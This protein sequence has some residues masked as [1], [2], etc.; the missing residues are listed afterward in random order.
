MIPTGFWLGPLVRRPWQRGNLVAI[1]DFQTVMLPLVEALADG[2]ERTM[3]EV[4]DLLADRFNLTEQERQELLPLWV[5][6]RFSYLVCCLK[7]KSIENL[8]CRGF[9]G[10]WWDSERT[11]RIHGRGLSFPTPAGD[12][13]RWLESGRRRGSNRSIKSDTEFKSCRQF[14]DIRRV[15]KNHRFS[16]DNANNA[17]RC[18]GPTRARLERE[19]PRRPG[20]LAPTPSAACWPPEPKARRRAGLNVPPAGELGLPLPTCCTGRAAATKAACI[21]TAF[22]L[23]DRGVTE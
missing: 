17:H 22:A 1:P 7:L 14:R 8:G 3:R 2:Q 11:E 20:V 18:V 15:P 12:Q 16:T 5:S 6:V 10:N 21:G 9:S 4:T 23:I 19:P 13:A